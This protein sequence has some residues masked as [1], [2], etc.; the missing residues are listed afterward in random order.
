MAPPAAAV[1][2]LILLFLS[3]LYGDAAASPCFTFLFSFG[4]SLTDTGNHML[5][6]PSSNLMH[7]ASFPDGE[8]FFGWPTSRCSD[9]LIIIDFID[10]VHLTMG[11]D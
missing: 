7:S 1:K 8:T 4:D 5:L 6:I 11:N 3:I 2:S 9:G 10:T